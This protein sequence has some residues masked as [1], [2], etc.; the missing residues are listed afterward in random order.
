M[1]RTGPVT[2]LL[3]GSFNPAHGGHRRI[4]LFAKHALGLDEVWWLVSP[5]NPLKPRAG[6]A[7]LATRCRS[8]RAQA[9]RAPI[10]VTAIERE[11][12]TV[13]TADTLAALLRRYPRRR[14]VWLMGAD[15]LAQ[16]HRWRQWRRIARQMPIA[17][18]ARP[19]YDGAAI[20]SPAMAWLRR[21]R[22]PAT[23]L[24]D[25][26]SRCRREWSAPALIEL[27][28]DPDPRS[29]TVV[30][31]SDPDWAARHSRPINGAGLRDQLTHRLIHDSAP[32]DMQAR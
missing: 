6:M 15:N 7:P 25:A 13:F 20:A 23:S 24:R 9:R 14:F 2:G 8:A 11:L 30:R 18:I 19:G 16:F 27:R 22:L 4:S 17:V 21:Y 29:A 26:K 12:D 10:V 5:G 28:F 3:G 32:P 31:L 1:N